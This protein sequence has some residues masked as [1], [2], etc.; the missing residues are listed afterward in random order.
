TFKLLQNAAFI[1]SAFLFALLIASPQLVQSS[2][3]IF[4][5]EVFSNHPLSVMSFESSW[6][7]SLV[8]FLNPL[9]PYSLGPSANDVWTAATSVRRASSEEFP[10]GFYATGGFL[11][12]TGALSAIKS[13]SAVNSA[14]AATGI[15]MLGTLVLLS[16]TTLSVWH[17]NWINLPRYCTPVLGAIGAL[18]IAAG[19]DAIPS[20]R[21]TSLIASALLV[22]I[23]ATL[24]IIIIVLRVNPQDVISYPM[25]VH[26][27][28]LNAISIFSMA[29]ILTVSIS[30]RVSDDKKIVASLLLFLADAIFQFR[31]GF[32]LD[33]DLLRL[34]P[35]A[36]MAVGA[37]MVARKKSPMPAIGVAASLVFGFW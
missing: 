36:A 11:A 29:A 7:L 8:N 19:L 2:R 35:F 17:F 25:L 16:Y 28:L 12:I 6:R 26:V 13:K 14:T 34:V 20:A 3:L 1:A 32:G 33:G 37:L 15:F 9:F 5:G 23:A 22:G 30:T 31:Y 24:L 21:K 18:L 4:S 10:I 27:A